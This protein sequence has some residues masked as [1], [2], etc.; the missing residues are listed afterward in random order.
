MEK[1]NQLTG[2]RNVKEQ[3]EKLRKKIEY[4][5]YRKEK[6]GIEQEKNPGYHF[7]FTGNPG[8]GKTTVARLLGDIFYHLGI[9]EKGHLVETDR[10]GIV[11]EFIGQTA[12][13]T[14]QKIEEAMGGVLFI[15]EAYA[16]ARAGHDSNDFGHEAIDTLI[17]EMEDKRGKF[18]VILAGYKDEMNQ[19][20]KMNPGLSSRINKR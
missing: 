2:L 13:L 20:L 16:L 5:Q 9:L 12:K 15:D 17:K 6:L 14:K 11:G 19:L 18:V 8:T 10:S 1:L 4:D 3:I 7:V